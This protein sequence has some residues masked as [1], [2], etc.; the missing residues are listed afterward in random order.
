MIRKIRKIALYGTLGTLLL[1]V[2]VFTSNQYIESY[3]KPYLFNEIEQ[4][5]NNDVGIVLGTSKYSTR[6]GINPYFSYRM[7]ATNKLYKEGKIK[8]IIVSGDNH[9]HGYNEPQQMKEYLMGLGI[10]PEDITLDYAGFRTFDTMIRGKEVFGQNSY[11]IISQEF[12]N[13]RA[14]FIARNFGINVVGYNA[15]SPYLSRQMKLRELL[16]K[17]KAVLD[18]YFLPTKPKFLGEKIEITP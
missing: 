4:L 2:S 17:F 3:S 6:G 16:A 1:L 7:M 18:V 8:H 12:H 5:P 13:E 9:K 14:V 10:P 11:T 15:K